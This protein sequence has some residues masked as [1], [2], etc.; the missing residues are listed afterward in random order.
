MYHAWLCRL[1]QGSL[2]WQCLLA[3]THHYQTR[4][5]RS[6]KIEQKEQKQDKRDNSNN[7]DLHKHTVILVTVH[8]H[9]YTTHVIHYDCH[10]ALLLEF[11]R[12][13]TSVLRPP[14]CVR[15]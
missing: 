4:P 14:F 15:P 13:T 3:C 6:E 2:S 7:Y 11:P 1:L 9:N 5:Q 8:V 12:R 10:I